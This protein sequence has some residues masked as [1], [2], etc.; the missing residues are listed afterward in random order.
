MALA[1]FDCVESMTVFVSVRKYSVPIKLYHFHNLS[2]SL[3]SF[4]T[5]ATPFLCMFNCPVQFSPLSSLPS[6]CDNGTA[7][8]VGKQRAKCNT[9]LTLSWD[10]ICHST[11][12]FYGLGH[13][14]GLKMAQ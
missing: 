12:Q 14:I 6:A 9:H 13:Y 3:Y 7:V 10:P 5:T 11:S 4:L 1:E 8:S 2:Q